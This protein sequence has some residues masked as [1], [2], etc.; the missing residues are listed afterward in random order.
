MGVSSFIL[1]IATQGP[2]LQCASVRREAPLGCLSPSLAMSSG[3]FASVFPLGT[4]SS[5]QPREPTLLLVF[6]HSFSMPLAGSSFSLM[7]GNV[8]PGS[9]HGQRNAFPLQAHCLVIMSHHFSPGCCS[10]LFTLTKGPC[11]PPCRAQVCSVHT[12]RAGPANPAV[13]GAKGSDY[14]DTVIEQ[15]SFD[16]LP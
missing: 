6:H 11:A 10:S 14:R 1:C 8:F 13:C 9:I 16:A 12:H 4:C 5:S 7:P 15:D 2:H 3:S